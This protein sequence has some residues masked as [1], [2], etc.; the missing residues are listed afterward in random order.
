MC[1][2]SRA[3]AFCVLF[4]LSLSG[5][6]V[7]VACMSMHGSSEQATGVLPRCLEQKRIVDLLFV[8]PPVGSS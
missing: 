7:I 4:P 6:K 5:G 2:E 3:C 8:H 1:G